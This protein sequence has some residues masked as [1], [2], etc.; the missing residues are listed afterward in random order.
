MGEFKDLQV[1]LTGF[2]LG[3]TAKEKPNLWKYGRS[4]GDTEEAPNAA[5]RVKNR[6]LPS[7]PLDFP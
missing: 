7:G 2:V 5:W 4:G 3:F 1:K 6:S